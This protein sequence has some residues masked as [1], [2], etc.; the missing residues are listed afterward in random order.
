MRRNWPW[1]AA[2]LF[3][4][5]VFYASR[6]VTIDTWDGVQAARNALLAAGARLPSDC[7]GFEVSRPPLGWL[8]PAP[9]LA[10]RFASAGPFA[11]LRL[12]QDLMILAAAA[13]LVVTHRLSSRF[14]S[15]GAAAAALLALLVN[16]LLIEFAP[17]VSTDLLAPFAVVLFFFA[18]LRY[19]EKPG[20][21]RYALL[22]GAYVAAFLTKYHLGILIALPL[23]WPLIDPKR[24]W[25]ARLA[26]FALNPVWLMPALC[27]LA[28]L[29]AWGALSAWAR[30]MPFLPAA[31]QA[32]QMLAHIFFDNVGGAASG[33]HAM[34]VQPGRLYY[35]D[36]LGYE[37]GWAAGPAAAV[38]LFV[39]CRGRDALRRHAAATL[40]LL[41][42]FLIFLLYR[43]YAHYA[44]ATVPFLY[45]A[46]AQGLDEIWN[47][48][49][50]PLHRKAALAAFVLLLPWSRAADSL[51]FLENNPSIRTASYRALTEAVEK[52]AA[53]GECVG[54]ES[55]ELALS[56]GRLPYEPQPLL[57]G[58]STLAYFADRRVAAPPEDRREEDCVPAVVV[59]PRDFPQAERREPRW[60]GPQLARV[61]RGKRLFSEIRED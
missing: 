25:A 11:V 12:F 39:W 10:W 15:A 3:A 19:D 23:G 24:R 36:M 60:D 51:A 30:G 31:G 46:A 43:P 18:A 8:L 55:G 52:A 26:A 50:K 29:C 57:F 38:G 58:R 20:P 56:V 14:A 1:L 32:H 49:K 45:A 37:L 2:A 44:F 35:F 6:G 4:S 7:G 9:L 17:F 28:A 53:P 54:W 22:L 47:R 13:L 21:A 34:I 61:Y 33:A 27:W 5:A 48:L 59:V 40:A 41:F 42:G 16:P